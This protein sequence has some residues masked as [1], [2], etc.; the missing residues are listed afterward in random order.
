M[1]KLIMNIL[2]MYVLQYILCAWAKKI[3][4]IQHF[5]NKNYYYYY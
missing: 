1:F 3:P 4:D 2:N 5:I